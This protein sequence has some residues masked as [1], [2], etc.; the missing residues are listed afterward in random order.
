M[1]SENKF[2]KYLIYAIGEIIL[3]VIGILLALQINNW[4]ENRKENAKIDTYLESMLVDLNNDA[5]Y[6]ERMVLNF[7]KEIKVNSSIFESKEYQT[8]SFDSIVLKITS[9]FTDYKIINQTFQK[10]ENSGLANRLG[11]EKLNNAIND[12]Y[13]VDLYSFNLYID[14]D[15]E[16]SLRDDEFWFVTN[17]YE[18]NPPHGSGQKLDLPFSDNEAARKQAL[19]K[20]IES[21]LGRNSL[22]NNISR[23]TLGKRI[24]KSLKH[25]AELLTELINKE[26]NLK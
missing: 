20:R 3:V 7:D 15:E 25:K 10:I 8:L 23:K 22:R 9:Y 4:N 21:N 17:E 14:Y 5:T 24:T 19:I 1:L 12:Y 2:S 18:I 16:R 13:T 11:S 26:L 6:F